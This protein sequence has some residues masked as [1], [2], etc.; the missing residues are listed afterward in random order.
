MQKKQ[1]P[2]LWFILCQPPPPPPPL[3]Q[4]PPPPPLCQPPPP[5]WQYT[6]IYW[7]KIF[8]QFMKSIHF[9]FEHFNLI[10]CT[11]DPF[12]SNLYQWS[13][14]FIAESQTVH[15]VMRD[16]FKF[17][18][19]EVKKQFVQQYRFRKV[20]WIILTGQWILDWNFYFDFDFISPEFGMWRILLQ[21]KRIQGDTYFCLAFSSAHLI[22]S[23]LRRHHRRLP[24]S[25][26]MPSQHKQGRTQIPAI[27]TKQHIF[28]FS[29]TDHT[30]KYICKMHIAIF[31][32]Q[33]FCFKTLNTLISNYL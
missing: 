24:R 18:Y 16:A 17:S 2:R 12:M 3:C 14:I 26:L 5:P 7:S 20:Y 28:Q 22:A 10:K 13:F 19:I 1:Q 21:S 9:G 27:K 4:P 11:N 32:H 31:M 8:T 23:H 33:T 25:R 30:R 6:R 29:Y 15:T